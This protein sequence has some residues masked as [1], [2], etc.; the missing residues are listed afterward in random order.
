MARKLFNPFLFAEQEKWKT[1]RKLDQT[2]G[3]EYLGKQEVNTG[4]VRL[5]NFFSKQHIIHLP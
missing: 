3:K 4:L 2:K 5:C 1:K